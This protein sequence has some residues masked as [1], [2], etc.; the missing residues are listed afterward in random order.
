MEDVSR[1]LS[2]MPIWLA[3]PCVCP[4]GQRLKF[5]PSGLTLYRVVYPSPNADTW[6]RLQEKRHISKQAPE[7]RTFPFSQDT[8]VG[9]SFALLMVGMTCMAVATVL[10]LCECCGKHQVADHD[11]A[12]PA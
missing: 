8:M 3:Y 5:S 4:E 1:C 10:S 12:S 7:N 2:S 11:G 6:L 9:Y